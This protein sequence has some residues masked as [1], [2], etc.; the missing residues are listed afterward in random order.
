L[1]YFPGNIRLICLAKTPVVII[2]ECLAKRFC[3]LDFCCNKWLWA[4]FWLAH[5]PPP[6]FLRRFFAAL[7]DFC[8]PGRAFPGI[9]FLIKNYEL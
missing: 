4:G 1:N 9:Y 7:D 3:L 6:V 8:F 2:E 5:F